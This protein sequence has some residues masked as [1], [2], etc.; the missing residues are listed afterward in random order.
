MNEIHHAVMRISEKHVVVVVAASGVCVTEKIR[1]YVK[2]LTARSLPVT[3][4]I[5]TIIIKLYS[6]RKYSIRFFC[7]A[8]VFT[9][10]SITRLCEYYSKL[11]NTSTSR[12][13]K[14]SDS[15]PA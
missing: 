4:I 5:I 6:L 14:N 8:G 7:T 10:F 13:G 2:G 11:V 12:V 9:T 15:I 3:V 1:F